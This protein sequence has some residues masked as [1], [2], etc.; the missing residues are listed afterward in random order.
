MPGWLNRPFSTQPPT[1]FGERYLGTLTRSKRIDVALGRAAVGFDA[2]EARSAITAV[3]LFD[4]RTK[5][6]FSLPIHATQAVVVAAGGMGNAQLLLQPAAAGPPVGN[7]SGHVGKYL[8]E[9]PHAYGAGECVTDLQFGRYAPPGRFGRSIPALVPESA[10]EIE[11]GLLG[12]SLE[13]DHPAADGP[14]VD[15]LSTP[16]RTFTHY[17]LVARS[18]MRPNA[19]NRVEIMADASRSGLY[20]VS[21]RCVFDA[22]DL[23]NVENTMRLLGETLIRLDR[24]RV[25]VNNDAIYRDVTGGGHTMGT[26]RMGRIASSSVVDEHCRV[27][28]YRNFFVAGSSV[29]PT[30]GY[31]NPTF[32]IMALAVRLADYIDGGL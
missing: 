17:R 7:E 23:R 19:S 28:G 2:T 30:V 18:E 22:D 15:Q 9:H 13:F 6:K 27:H 10:F 3:R 25:R 26:T 11:H 20:R 29:F 12:C 5:S 31:A 21:A 1:R 24:G 16:N 4:Q 32:T 8:M 14:L